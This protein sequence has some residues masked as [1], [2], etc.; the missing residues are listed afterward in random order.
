[1][2]RTVPESASRP[3]AGASGRCPICDGRS[4][5]QSIAPPGLL[6]ARC[7][8]CGHR[9]AIHETGRGPGIDYHEQYDDGVFLEALRATRLR[10]AGRLILLLRRHVPSLSGVVDYGAGRGWFLEACRSAGV[11]PVA[12][13]DTSQLSVDGLAASGIEA[14][15][16]P[17]DESGAEVLS[18]LSFSPRVVSLLDVL[19]HFPPARLQTRLR[20]IVD[21]C[22]KE[23]ELVVVKVPVAGVLYDVAAGL[24]RVGAPRLLSQL[25]QAGTWPPHFN[26]F[27]TASAEMLLTSIGLS[28]IERVG[29]PDFEPDRLGQ[30]IGMTRP[31][32]R[33]LARI[34]GEALGAAIHITGLF[35][36]A[37]FLARPTRALPA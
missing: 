29:D 16:L 1:L 17:E 25:Y 22:G 13:V 14:H 2:T 21:A 8:A 12:G 33:A 28:V 37:V 18:R 11:A 23:L 32:V 35:D 5:S 24:C 31:V 15:R 20:S 4:L 27:S 30:R 3:R 26:Y 9:V 34:G 10:Q 7:R 19:E 36:S 6:V